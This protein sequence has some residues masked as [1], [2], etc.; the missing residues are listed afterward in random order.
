MNSLFYQDLSLIEK[1]PNQFKAYR[2]M[3]NTVLIAGPGS[4]KTRVLS[5][6]A[7]SLSKSHIRKPEG[8]ACIS[9]S[10]ESVRELRS[11]LKQ[12]GYIPTNKDFIGTVHSFSLL[13]VL[14][15]FAHLY[16]EYGIKYPIKIISNEI[17]N[18]IYNRVLTEI[19]LTTKELRFGDIQK[20]RALALKGISSVQINSSGP[21][22]KAAEIY[23]KYLLETEYLDFT[24]IINFSATII[25]EKEFVRKTLKCR[26]PWLLVDEY[27]DLGKALHEMVLELVFNAGIK[28][29]AVGDENQSIYGFN[30]GY[31]DFLKELTTY[32]DIDP[33][34][35]TANYRSSKH[36]IAASLEALQLETPH[37]DYT[38]QR[39]ITDEADFTFIVCKEDMSEQFQTVAE[40]VIPKL[41]KEEVSLNEI[42]ILLNSNEEVAFMAS[43]LTYNGIPF[44]IAKWKFE[45]SAV[46]VWLQECASWCIEKSSQSF[47]DLFKFWVSLLFNH[48]DPR[49]T[50]DSIQLKVMFHAIITEAKS[51]NETLEW[52][53][54][55]LDKLGLC[56]TLEGSEM[57][58]NEVENLEC[59]I[60]EARLHNLK[61]TSVER[62][63]NLGSP[64]NEVTIT[65][66]HSSK[67][68][69]F[70]TV[71]MLGMDEDKFPNFYNQN[72]PLAIAED[73][74]LCYVCVSRAKLRCILLRSSIYNIPTKRGNWAKPFR[75]SR[76]WVSLHKKFGDA[77]N[78]FT[79]DNYI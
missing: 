13:H 75:P 45:N 68:L 34:Y 60:D 44:F 48:D 31:P 29:Y 27:Q 63:A 2:S 67:G 16:P 39:L 26:F 50:L 71:I 43:V 66:R 5:L 35:L 73:H 30:G 40:R 21:V 58:P 49:K 72:N 3:N 70:E 11:R 23:E 7:V 69:E 28:L 38:A 41:L 47:Q 51:I 64:N 32:A 46:L 33:V 22:S 37:P 77:T 42:G 36:I 10:R 52:I 57:Y 15:P 65:T 8:L 9:F 19:G 12:Y 24:S 74:R 56:K 6:K 14:Q 62:L 53:K 25:R 54:F 76:F 55:M 20:Q 1:D 59:L 61:G 79:S 4:G 78:T 17:S 18:K